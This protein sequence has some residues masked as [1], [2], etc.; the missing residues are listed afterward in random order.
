MNTDQKV[1]AFEELIDEAS[2]AIADLV[3]VVKQRGDSGVAK[4]MESLAA[5]LK[6]STDM[7]AVVAELRALRAEPAINVTVQPSP[8]QFSSLLEKGGEIEM[9]MPA[10]PGGRDKVAI[11]RYIPPTSSKDPK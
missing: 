10:P 4:A 9:R 6:G 11:F 8:V 1:R 7:R 5:A 2:Q 3:D